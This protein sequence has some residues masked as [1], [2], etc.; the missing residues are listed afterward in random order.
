MRIFLITNKNFASVQPTSETSLGVLLVELTHPAGGR[1]NLLV[2]KRRKQRGIEPSSGL[3]KSGCLLIRHG[4]NH[5]WYQNPETKV[6][7]PVPR[8]REIVE[9]LPSI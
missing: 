2:R 8:H 4:G 1:K 9:S 6:C 3:N 5:D 7:Q